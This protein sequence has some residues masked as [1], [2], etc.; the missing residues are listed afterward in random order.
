M[1]ARIPSL[2][3]LLFLYLSQIFNGLNLSFLLMELRQRHQLLSLSV[4]Q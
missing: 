3:Q 4:A 1:A 2:S